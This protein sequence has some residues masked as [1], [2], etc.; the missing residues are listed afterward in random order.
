MWKTRRSYSSH[1][2][3]VWR[4][5]YPAGN[6]VRGQRNGIHIRQNVEIGPDLDHALDEFCPSVGTSWAFKRRDKREEAK[7]IF[8]EVRVERI[9][10]KVFC[11]HRHHQGP[12]FHHSPGR[13]NRTFHPVDHNG[14]GNIHAMHKKKL[15]ARGA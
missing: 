14:K 13:H 5:W 3:A 10:G 4:Q 15:S 8:G 6:S 7:S 9:Q 12:G 2:P 11:V 1:R